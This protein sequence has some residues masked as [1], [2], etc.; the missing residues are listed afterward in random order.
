MVKVKALINEESLSTNIEQFK[1]EIRK[2]RQEI[3]RKV[4]KESTLKIPLQQVNL[5]YQRAVGIFNANL[6]NLQIK[7]KI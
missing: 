7:L 4:R 5:L 2:L 6:L 3:S 1:E